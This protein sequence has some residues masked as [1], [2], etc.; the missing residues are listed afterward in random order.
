MDVPYHPL[1]LP[2]GVTLTPT[3][4]RC[5]SMSVNY[6]TT[7]PV[8]ETAM[9]SVGRDTLPV[10]RRVVGHTRADGK[11]LIDL[12]NCTTDVMIMTIQTKPFD[13]ASVITE[14]FA[15]GHLTDIADRIAEFAKLLLYVLTGRG[16]HAAEYVHSID[17]VS[18]RY[19]EV[20]N[21][22]IC[23]EYDQQTV[24]AHAVVT[25]RSRA[26]AT[27]KRVADARPSGRI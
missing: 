22:T 27:S 13:S 18:G 3:A 25:P 8:E 17:V 5:T 6:H 2:I 1:D 21:A 15:C 12:E 20:F 7:H 10:T 24:I 9:R 26:R 14:T 16:E 11:A 4:T 23:D 19:A